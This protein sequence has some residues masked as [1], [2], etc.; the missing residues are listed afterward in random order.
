MDLFFV[1]SG[2]LITGILWESRG[3]KHYFRN[4]YARRTLRLFPLYYGTLVLI[5]LLL[6]ALMPWVDIHPRYLSAIG[7]QIRATNE[8]SRYRI[9]YL[10]YSVDFLVAI[11]GFIFPTHFWSLAVEEHFYLLWPLLVQRL[12]YNNLVKATFITFLGT[13]VLR[14]FFINFVNRFALYA[15][16]PF[17]LDGLALGSLIAL[18]LRDENGGALMKNIARRSLPILAGLCIVLTAMMQG[19]S[20]YGVFAQTI[21]Y[22][23]TAVLYASILILT[24]TVNSWAEIFSNRILCFFGK[25]SFGLY[26]IHVFVLALADNLFSL[27]NPAHFSLLK[28]FSVDHKTLFDVAPKSAL[29]V[30]CSVYIIFA[31]GLSLLLAMVSWHFIEA[32]FLKFKKW[33]PYEKRHES[34][35]SELILSLAEKT[36]VISSP[37]NQSIE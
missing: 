9:W 1:L 28:N 4:F 34:T 16:T 26:V 32:P 11:R 10:T 8:A 27:G 12:S 17:R 30:D 3:A 6:P 23:V 14:C 37:K 13:L 15:F 29:W 21:G 5:F 7:T 18:A 2:F 22:S 19:W 33:F 24:L 25:Y 35:G 36:G 31:L 20:Q